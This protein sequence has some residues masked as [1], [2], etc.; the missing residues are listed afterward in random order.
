M[1]IEYVNEEVLRRNGDKE[2][3]NYNQNE[4]VKIFC[5]YEDMRM[6]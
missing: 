3:D 4:T 6:V 5:T 1:E 2:D